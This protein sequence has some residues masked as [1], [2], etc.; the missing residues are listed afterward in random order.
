LLRLKANFRFLDGSE[1]GGV[2]RLATP[3]KTVGVMK[4]KFRT[5][6]KAPAKR[7]RFGS[8]VKRLRLGNDPHNASAA[9]SAY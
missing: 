9:A 3:S 8:T 6:R 5:Q 7:C 4:K 2:A 1:K